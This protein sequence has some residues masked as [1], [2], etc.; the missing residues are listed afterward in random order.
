V[1][2]G[3]QKSYQLVQDFFHPPCHHNPIQTIVW[4]EL[5]P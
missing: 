5:Y 2:H 3:Y 4:A 1:F